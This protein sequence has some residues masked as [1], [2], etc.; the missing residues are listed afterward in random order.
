VNTLS[1]WRFDTPDGAEAALRT[2]ERLQN[3]RRVTVDDASVVAWPTG[4]DRPRTYQAG[5]AAGTAALSGAFWGLLF[6]VV[7]LLPLAGVTAGPDGLFRVGLSDE[8]LRQVRD[9]ITPGTS[10]LFLL[11]HDA[12]VDRIRETFADA[13]P[14]ISTLDRD[15]EAALLRAFDADD[16][17]TR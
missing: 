3:Q 9:R 6:G 12:A 7:F 2:L 17:T 14:L 5:T 16:V 10:A 11:T 15:Q 4:N 8:F 13:E 1:V